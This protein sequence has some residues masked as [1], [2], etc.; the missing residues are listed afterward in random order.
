M[1]FEDPP[2]SDRRTIPPVSRASAPSTDEGSRWLPILVATC[3]A[4][5]A[6]AATHVHGIRS[7]QAGAARDVDGPRPVIITESVRRVARETAP[8]HR[9]RHDDTV[10][11]T[12]AVVVVRGAPTVFVSE[13]DYRFVATPVVLGDVAAEGQRVVSG[14]SP[15]QVV[16][17]DGAEALK[18]HLVVQ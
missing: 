8:G 9:A 5:A 2:S 7:M 16:V 6:L 15:G 11:P 12:S 3:L 13:T 18:A 17:S 14:V 10:V 4:G 1:P